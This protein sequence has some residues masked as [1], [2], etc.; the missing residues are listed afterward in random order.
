VSAEQFATFHSGLRDAER[1]LIDV[2]AREPWNVSAWSC[3]LPIAMG[4]QLGTSEARRRYARLAMTDPH[5]HP[6]QTALLQ[7]LCPKWGGS[8]AE[9]EAFAQ[10]CARSAPPG[11]LHGSLPAVVHLERW[12][13]AGNRKERAAY[14]GR[15]EVLDELDA[16][17]RASVLHPSFRPC[18]GENAVHGLFA[19]CYSL[20]GAHDRAAP[21]FRRLDGPVST[22]P[23]QYVGDPGPMFDK[24]CA[25][26]LS[27]AAQR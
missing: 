16:A 10:E 24:A 13:D 21:H 5:H 18:A 26:A 1:I 8:W 2:T 7:Q 17:A 20:A 27:P 11:G 23:W 3:R 9:A 12:S 19:M 15:P 14:L 25:R 4:L 22:W 6:S